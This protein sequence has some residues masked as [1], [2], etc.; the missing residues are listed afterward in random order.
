MSFAVEILYVLN[1]VRSEIWESF[2]S[3]QAEAGCCWRFPFDLVFY[4]PVRGRS[5]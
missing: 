1:E 4:V 3:S 5:A 2:E